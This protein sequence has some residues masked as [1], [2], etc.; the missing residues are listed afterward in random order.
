[1]VHYRSGDRDFR[2][3]YANIGALGYWR[4]WLVGLW[5]G[6]DH[7]RLRALS[8]AFAV[9][10][11]FVHLGVP[12]GSSFVVLFAGVSLRRSSA[13]MTLR[14]GRAAGG[15]SVGSAGLLRP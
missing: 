1:M 12:R 3:G 10:S 2:S 6:P 13:T 14:S 7:I 5:V 4:G 9:V 15:L 11:P 8:S